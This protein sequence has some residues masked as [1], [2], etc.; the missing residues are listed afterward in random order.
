MKEIFLFLENKIKNKKKKKATIANLIVRE[1][2]GLA[3]SIMILLVIKADD[4]RTTKINGK[5]LRI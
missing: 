3:L 2:N 5:I 1:V 4:Q